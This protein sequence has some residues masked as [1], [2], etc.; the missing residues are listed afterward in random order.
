MK[1]A[2]WVCTGGY[3]FRVKTVLWLLALAALGL[4]A[5]AMWRW[6]E[7]WRERQR[8][9]EARMAELLAQARAPTPP[10]PTLTQQRLLFEAAVKTGDAGEPAL[11]IELY[12][13]LLARFPQ[14]PFATQARSAIDAQKRRLAKA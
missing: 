9:S 8:T 13:R 5:Y 1:S 12:G 11:S 4:F 3:T 14:S 6:R 7:R 2:S 10:D